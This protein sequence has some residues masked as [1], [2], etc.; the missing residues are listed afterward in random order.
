MIYDE[1][2][3]SDFCNFIAEKVKY[4]LYITVAD[5]LTN[6]LFDV[7]TYT[8]YYMIKPLF[9]FDSVTSTNLND[10]T[11]NNNVLIIE[12]NNNT[13]LSFKSNQPV[14][15]YDERTTET[16]IDNIKYTLHYTYD[17]VTSEPAPYKRT[18]NGNTTDEYG[19]YLDSEVITDGD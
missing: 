8:D 10:N 6:P 19:Y 11:S 1:G 3:N 18:S 12:K 13:R 7:I 4:N 9:N 14:I 15:D 16:I 17:P 2:L 5:I